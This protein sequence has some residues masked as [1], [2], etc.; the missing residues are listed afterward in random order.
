MII[1]QRSM[2]IHRCILEL[3]RCHVQFLPIINFAVIGGF[4]S[5]TCWHLHRGVLSVHSRAVD[6][7]ILVEM[8][9]QSLTVRC[10]LKFL[11]STSEP[12][13]WACAALDNSLSCG[14]PP[15]PKKNKWS[16]REFTPATKTCFMYFCESAVKKE[17]CFQ[18]PWSSKI[19]QMKPMCKKV[20]N[21]SPSDRVQCIVCLPAK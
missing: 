7:V 21:T 16:W 1:I 10:K 19:V 18:I 14:N 17:H 5:S 15:P 13:C 8:L 4:S 2:W 3:R 20:L 12:I 11:S 9:V 6:C